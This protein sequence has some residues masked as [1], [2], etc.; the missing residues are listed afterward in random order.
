MTKGLNLAHIQTS[1]PKI[2]VNILESRYYRF[3]L[4]ALK[5]TLSHDKRLF[6]TAKSNSGNLV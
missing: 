1:E 4:L 3:L 5:N 2:K 6:I